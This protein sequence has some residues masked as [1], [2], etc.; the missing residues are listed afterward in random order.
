M[1]LICVTTPLDSGTKYILIKQDTMETVSK[2]TGPYSTSNDED[3][4]FYDWLIQ[5]IK[6]LGYEKY[7]I[8]FD[9]L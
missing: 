5:E 6:E 2:G 1:E 4:L 8:E 9:E 3:D 7:H